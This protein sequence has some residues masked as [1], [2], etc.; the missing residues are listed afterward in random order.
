MILE[1]SALDLSER[2]VGIHRAKVMEE[3][4]ARSVAHLVKLQL[5]L[6]SKG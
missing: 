6:D 2:T 4:G 1:L 3:M 5:S